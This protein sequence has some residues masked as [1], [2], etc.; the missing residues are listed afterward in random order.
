MLTAAISSTA[1]ETTHQVAWLPSVSVRRA[2]EGGS[3]PPAPETRSVPGLPVAER[4]D[5]VIL[6]V[7]DQP[8]NLR[9]LER[10]LRRAGYGTIIT[11]TDSRD[12]VALVE[13][14]R[15]DLVLLDWHMPLMDG[16]EV[17]KAL[18]GQMS[19]EDLPVV[20]LSAE[21]APEA[22]ATALALGAKDFIMKPFEAAEVL[23]RTRNLL[24]T[25]R[26]QDELRRRNHD[27]EERLRVRTE[28]LEDAHAGTLERLARAVECRDD[29][30]GQHT[31]RVGELSAR[32]ASAM[33]LSDEAVR[34]I[35]AAAP[36]HDVG[37]IGIPDAILFK[38]GPLSPEEFAVMSTHTTIGAQLLAGGR[39]PI[40]QMAER[41]AR[42]H[43]E[44]W[45]GAGY[46]DRLGGTRI[47][48]EAR[49]VAVADFFD[50]L[51]SDRPYRRAWSVERTLDA[52]LAS[53]GTHFDPEVVDAFI[54]IV[55]AAEAA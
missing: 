22:K 48:L 34:L 25:R 29:E 54:R 41:I 24:E 35:R 52:I 51:T 19:A 10:M 46:P 12:T 14:H 45:D 30:T 4:P 7:D 31:L 55:A 40:N 21:A 44:R 26:L 15:P 53:R 11:T 50:A 1:P 33:G 20:I 47:P 38:P 36:L 13:R 5:S 32:I 16:M 28:A 2:T 49:I 43:H 23:L 9:I 3:E 37:K 39:S 27:L 18:S 17:L 6:A 8:A 42:S